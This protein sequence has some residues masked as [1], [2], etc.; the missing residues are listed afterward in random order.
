[1]PNKHPSKK[2]YTSI[3]KNEK[4]AKPKPKAMPVEVP[5]EAPVE[6]K[7]ILVTPAG[8]SNEVL[9]LIG[10]LRNAD[11]DVA[12]EAAASLGSHRFDEV[13]DALSAAVM[14][15]E[16]YFH[17]VV[18]AAAAGSLGRLN[19]RRA[20][21]ALLA[22]V[23]D[24]MAEASAES[25]RAL[26]AIADPAALETLAAVVENADGFYLPVVRL[27]AVKAMSRFDDDRAR[28]VSL[29]VAHNEKEDAVIR[30]AARN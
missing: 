9:S 30:A 4:A 24:P 23:R 11:A 7:L 20:L 15:A 3:P 13:V 27:A 22:G 5:V 16:G 8:P 26:A 12:S 18:R 25:V 17:P 14:N 21:P 1:M 28:A 6:K 29:A 19:D 2:R 10:S